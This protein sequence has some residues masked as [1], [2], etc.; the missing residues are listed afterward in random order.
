MPIYD[1]TFRRYEGPRSVGGLWRVVARQTLRPI[2]RSKLAILLLVGALI[3]ITFY[4]VMLYVGAKAAEL[5]PQHTTEQAAAAVRETGIPLFGRETKLNSMLFDFVRAETAL[6]WLLILVTGGGSISSDIRNQALPLYFSR[7]LRP[8]DYIIGKVLGLAV[9]PVVVVCLA[10]L[11]VYMQAIAYFFPVAE[12]WKQAHLLLAG[13]VYV[14]GTSVFVALLMAAFSSASRRAATAAVSF[15]GFFALTGV[16]SRIAERA[17]HYRQVGTLSPGLDLQVLAYHLFKPEMRNV[18]RAMR[19]EE[20][21]L[22]LVLLALAAYV[23]VALLV[24][25][26]N[27]KVVEVVK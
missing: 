17:F 19:V 16:V 24:I 25:R 14:A 3:H 5:S 4:S 7:P 9:A 6:V 22:S 2:I 21:Q 11:L 10:I 27:L 15:L 26:R 8:R 20:Y 13:F 1:Q 12:L 18:R 23:L